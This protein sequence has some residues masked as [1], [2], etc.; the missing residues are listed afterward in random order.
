MR[1]WP[2]LVF[3]LVA[4]GGLVAAG[5]SREERPRPS[6]GRAAGPAMPVA[7]PE[8]GRSS[9][10]F[11]AA[12]A[13]KAGS[14]L[15]LTVTVANVA[16]QARTARITWY[17]QAG[18]PVTRS[19]AVPAVSSVEVAATSALSS[20]T[21]SALV[22][23]DGGGVA[24]E[25]SVNGPSG[26]ATAPC[27]SE[28]SSTWYL[29]VGVTELDAKETVVLFNPFPA[30]AVV[31]LHFDTESG[32]VNPP[33]GQ[34][35]PIP[36]RS[37]VYVP[38]TDLVRRRAVVATEVVARAGQVVVDRVQV[39][40]GTRG[41][42]GIALS[43]A[44]PRGALLWEFPDGFTKPSSVS[45]S[46]HV[47]NPADEDAAIT[48]SVDPVTGDPPPPLD[49]TVPPRSQLTITTEQA[50]VAANVAYSS[51]IESQNGVRV[52]AERLVDVR[53][54][55]GRSGWSSM[56]GSPATATRWLFPAGGTSSQ[57]DEWLV[58]RNPGA[59]DVEVSVLALAAGI[60]LPVEGL[61]GVKVAAGGHVAVRLGDHI[62]RSPLPLVVEATGRIVVERDLYGVG[63]VGVST[64]IGIPFA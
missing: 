48:L 15:D 38:V 28:S 27:A 14:L 58:L 47:Y 12:G 57:T 4:I 10:W 63:R 46:W 21:A 60:R 20:P 54:I 25:H 52:V 62:K 24:V 26:R 7:A 30:D 23:V 19:V 6:F 41:R 44:A 1:R 31:D 49:L 17:P 42:K 36:A 16:D 3:L 9:T 55:G 32:K 56:L 43:V 2:A 40:D 29:P 35:L 18:A 34:G 53:D 37:T 13:A 61:Q 59:D 51:T 11:C 50:A 22:E 45:T 64:V 39:F 5:A 8:S 33:D